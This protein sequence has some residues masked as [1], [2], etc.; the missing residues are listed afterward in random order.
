MTDVRL[1]LFGSFG[2]AGD[3]APEP[4]RGVIPQAIIAR[5]ALARRESIP[6]EQLVKDLWS[7][8]PDMVL[9]S[10]RAHVS[11]LRA[12]GWG[13]VLSGGRNGYRLDLGDDQVDVLE[14]QL[15]ASGPAVDPRGAGGMDRI[16]QL[17]AAEGLWRADP[18]PWAAGFPFRSDAVAR[19]Q[20]LRRRATLELAQLRTDSGAPA[21]VVASVTELVAG[22]PADGEMV[23]ALA[24]ALARAGRTAD[25][26][27]AIDVHAEHVRDLGLDLAPPLAELRLSIVRQ[28]PQV[29]GLAGASIDRVVE[30]SGI[31]I[32][33]TRFV[34]RGVD[35]ET[36]RRGRAESRLVTLT[37]AA[38]VGKTRLAVEVARRAGVDEDESQWLIDLTSIA[39][40]SDVVPAVADA[41]GAADHTIDAVAQILAGRRGLLI[42]DNAEHVLGTVATV[43]A[44]ILERCAGLSVLV[45][46]RESM[47]MAG[48]RVIVIEP[49]LGEQVDEAVDLFLQRATDSSGILGW[50]EAQVG[51]VRTMCRMLDGLPLAIELAASRLDVLSLDELAE[52]LQDSADGAEGARRHDSIDTAIEWSVRLTTPDERRMLGQLALFSGTFTLAM[53]SGICVLDGRDPREVAVALARK[54]L[55]STVPGV[56]ERRFRMLEAVKRYVRRNV[57]IDDVATWHERHARW[58]TEEAERLAPRLRSAEVK[59]T[60]A[61]LVATRPDFDAALTW[62]IEAGDRPVAMRL[63]AALAWFWCERGGG[64]D[65][66]D[67]IDRVIGMPGEPMPDAEAEALRAA[68]FIRAVGTDPLPLL[69]TTAR[70]VDV[71]ER[72][73]DPIHPML[74]RAMSAYLS[75]LAGNEADADAD[76]ELAAAA[77]ERVGAAPVWAVADYLLVRG[78]VL[79]S[80]G[81]PAQALE[82]LGESY[83][84]ALDTGNS[85]ALRGSGFVTGKTLVQV[86]RAADALG[87]LRSGALTSLE[88]DDPTSAMAAIN[89]FATALVALDRCQLAVEL[90]GAVEVLGARFNYAPI[91]SDGEYTDRARAR[92]RQALTAEEWQAAHDRGMTRDLRWI[93]AHLT[94]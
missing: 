18:L 67:L 6:A 60:K 38:G 77:R 17:T 70:L 50:E 64:P 83:R 62:A 10:L 71:A 49:L 5:L 48:E 26:L 3:A 7:D 82:A 33:L 91:A 57:R 34:G 69:R 65:A 19:L 16:A 59:Q 87:V 24:R 43:C 74:A 72:A 45:T 1:R 92:A 11:R 46:S 28:D 52:S 2:V 55:V 68:A 35:L 30:R 76:L 32:P 13:D 36:V 53:A 90:F 20:L 63:V 93:A 44:A 86:G 40:P 56:G 79:R 73:E 39:E 4:V 29:L 85:W 9:S 54:S 80:L 21:S 88:H 84:L 15:L 23:A 61:A 66:V 51:S 94:P 31:P 12:R 42:L 27:G 14:Y 81:R 89:V 8:P 78:D 75:A 37:G 58:L 47:R 25:A 41:V 22:D